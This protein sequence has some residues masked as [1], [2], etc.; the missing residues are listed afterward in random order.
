MIKI[1]NTIKDK[2]SQINSSNNVNQYLN[3]KNKKI[4]KIQ[5]II[6]QKVKIKI[7][8]KQKKKKQVL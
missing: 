1:E 8:I 2:V 7:Y 5:K 6:L 4:I 3:I